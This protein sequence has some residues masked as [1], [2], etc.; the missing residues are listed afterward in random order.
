MTDAAPIPS[1]TPPPGAATLPP[2]RGGALARGTVRLA[3]LWILAGALFKLFLGTPADLPATIRRLPL[4]L[5]L[6]YNLAITAELCVAGLTLLRPRWA[7]LPLCAMLLVFDWVLVGQISAGETSC[8]CFGSAIPISPWTMLAVD[9]LLL[10]AILGARP[11]RPTARGGAGVVPLIAVAAVAVALPWLFDRQVGPGSVEADGQPVRGAWLELDVE[12]WVGRDVWDTPLAEHVDVMTLPLDGL[13][14]FWRQTCDH[15]AEHLAELARTET[16]ERFVTLV[17][18]RESHDTE[19]NRVVHEMPAGP[20]VQHAT[21]PDSLT[22]VITT[23][24]EMVLE[25]G[26]IVEAHEGVGG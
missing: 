5:G 15:C 22:Y 3:G 10:A 2:T 8:G 21:L 19:A 9:T 17:Q 18:L 26:R 23:P 1:A 14:I 25:G 16:G 13:W 6:T 4:E 11:W 20:F 12:S 24:A 7:W